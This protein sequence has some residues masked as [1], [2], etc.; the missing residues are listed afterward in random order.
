MKIVILTLVVLSIAN[1]TSAGC[2]VSGNIMLGYPEHECSKP[3]VP[4]CLYDRSCDEW[5]VSDFKIQL[6]RY[7]NCINEYLDNVE[8]DIECAK[9]RASEAADEYNNFVKSF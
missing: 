3:F 8:I 1:L 6:K 9:Q 7:K 4:L 2:I 5:E